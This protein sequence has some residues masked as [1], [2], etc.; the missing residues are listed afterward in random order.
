VIIAYALLSWFRG[1]SSGLDSVYRMLGSVCEPFIGIFRR[2]L[3]SSLTGGSGIDLAPLVAI[4]ALSALQ[5]LVY[6]IR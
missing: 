2:I 6:M 1:T 4:L 3:P 5:R